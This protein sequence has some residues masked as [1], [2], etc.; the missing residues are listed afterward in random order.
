[1]MFY[2][3]N[4]KTEYLLSNYEYIYPFSFGNIISFKIERRYEDTLSNK[5]SSQEYG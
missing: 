5:I 2:R 1:M 3:S 4:I